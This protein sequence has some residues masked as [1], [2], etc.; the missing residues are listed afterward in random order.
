M[1]PPRTLRVLLALDVTL[2]SGDET[3]DH[4]AMTAA[5]WEAL[6]RIGLAQRIPDGT[7]ALPETWSVTANVQL[8]APLPPATEL[9]SPPVKVKP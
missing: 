7:A 5:Y 6:R 1:N 4:E 9:P 2:P 8:V 3:R